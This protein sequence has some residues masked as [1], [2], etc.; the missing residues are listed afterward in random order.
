MYEINDN[1]SEHT[2]VYDVLKKGVIK[3]GPMRKRFVTCLQKKK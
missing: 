2:N 1:V 3:Q